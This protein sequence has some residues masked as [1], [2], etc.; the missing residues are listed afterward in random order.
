ME[1]KSLQQHLEQSSKE[2]KRP[3]G[4]ATEIMMTI[5]EELGEV[6]Q[7]V[8]L[9]EQ[10]GSK[11]EW[12]KQPSKERLGEEMTHL[13]NVILTLAN[14]YEIHLDEIYSNQLSEK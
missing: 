5:V 12:Q 1:I 4:S 9:I 6:A 3:F 10:I 13:L 2:M 7:E 8:S 14:F 11:A